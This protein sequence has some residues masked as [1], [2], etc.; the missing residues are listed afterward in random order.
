MKIGFVCVEEVKAALRV[1]SEVTLITML[2]PKTSC[3][4][5]FRT[6]WISFGQAKLVVIEMFI[7]A[8]SIASDF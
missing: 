3:G 2:R 1:R 7:V 6:F 8:F 4:N 5:D